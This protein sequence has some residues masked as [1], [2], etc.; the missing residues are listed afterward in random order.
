VVESEYHEDDEEDDAENDRSSERREDYDDGLLQGSMHLLSVLDGS[1][2]T[3]PDLISST[4]FCAS[5]SPAGK[6]RRD[7]ADPASHCTVVGCGGRT[8]ATSGSSRYPTLAF[9]DC[10]YMIFATPATRW[11]LRPV[12]V[13]AS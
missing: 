13:C 6:H 11:R 12:R 9:P 3:W 10:I 8:S 4:D 1:K 5:S 7:H 2:G